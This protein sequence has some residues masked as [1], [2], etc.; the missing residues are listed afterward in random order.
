MNPRVLCRSTVLHIKRS[1]QQRQFTTTKTRFTDFTH[2]I[3]GG[4]VIGLSTAL[5]LA[6]HPSQPSVL[7]LERHTHPGT[8]TTAR[9]SSVIHAGLYYGRDS[10]KTRLCLRGKR[11]LYRWCEDRGVELSR[12]G[13]WLVAQDE[14]EL[15]VLEGVEKFARSIGNGMEYLASHSGDAIEEN[16]SPG[17]L[18]G[19][20]HDEDH[21]IPMRWLT[22][23]EAQRRESDV[24]AASGVLESSSTGIV[25]SHGLV[26]SL[27]AAF[28][29]AGGTVAFSTSVAALKPTSSGNE[30][31]V[32]TK[33]TSKV[34]KDRETRISSS[35]I[36][37]SAG[38]GAIPL[39]N[40][41]LPSDHPSQREPAYAK[42]TYYSY[43][44][45]TPR[46]RTLIYPI[47]VAGHGGLGTHL[48][49][50]LGG[51]VRFGPDVEWVSDPNDLNPNNSRL[52]EA[53]QEI[54]RY[55]PGLKQEGVHVDYCGVRPKLRK[56]ASGVAGP[57]FEDF[58]IKKE[59]GL[60]RGGELV[61]LLGMESPGLTASLAIGE[62]VRGLLYR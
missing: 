57:N 55:L 16:L 62:F 20:L 51:G 44:P 30:W 28:E 24:R 34:D 17:F 33:S 22:S 41:I 26:L 36:I 10:L 43:G 40:S 61:N 19:G 1:S 8:E 49:L 2:T 56:G 45:A 27:L 9:N 53:L 59:Q 4:G 60:E 35:T 23:E 52:E 37:N 54:K 15:A 5:S 50:D 3:I 13:K 38:N 39:S 47:P 21:V 32:W 14:R 11:M 25:D 12:C 58:Y 29:D 46:P 48:T 6:A 42:G 7:L 31:D 18:G